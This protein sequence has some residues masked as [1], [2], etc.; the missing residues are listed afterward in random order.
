MEGPKYFYKSVEQKK[1]YRTLHSL[2]ACYNYSLL[3]YQEYEGFRELL[4]SEYQQDRTIVEAYL[5]EIVLNWG[6]LKYQG[7]LKVRKNRIT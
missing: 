1:Y 3:N 5:E 4:D 7:K 2:Q 6:L